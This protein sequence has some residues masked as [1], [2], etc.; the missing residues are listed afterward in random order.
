MQTE[1][2]PREEDLYDYQV[3]LEE[4]KLAWADQHF[5]DIAGYLLI[6][7]LLSADGVAEA[8]KLAD[9]ADGFCPGP[10]GDEKLNAIE[11]GGVIEDAMTA[12]PIIDRVT[13]LIWGRQHRLVGSRV[14]RRPH[15][16]AS[17]LSQG[18]EAD[19]RRFARYRCHGSGDFRCL[20]LT[21]YIALQ[22]TSSDNGGLCAIGGSHKANL[23]HPYADRRLESVEPLCGLSLPAGA[24]V[25]LTENLSHAFAAAGEQ[26]HVWL[27]YHYGPSYMVNLPGCAPSDELLART[28]NDTEKSHLLLEPYYHPTGSQ[29]KRR[30]Q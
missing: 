3:G 11:L 2:P 20:M 25:V 7:D 18:G 24:A 19:P 14:I 23:P 8:R 21:C 27:S 17:P 1:A 30:E 13:Q 10:T 5:F 4:S 15:G 9:A 29:K 6:E 26:D 16:G 12:E 28:A 22:D